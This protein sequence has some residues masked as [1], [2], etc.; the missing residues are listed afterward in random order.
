MDKR[1]TNNNLKFILMHAIDLFLKLPLPY[2]SNANFGEKTGMQT[3][4]P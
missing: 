4:I 1:L 3:S 2:R